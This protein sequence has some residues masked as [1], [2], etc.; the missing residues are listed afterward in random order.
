MRK[1]TSLALALLA[2][3]TISAT[4]P[5]TGWGAVLHAGAALVH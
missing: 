4:M 3:S 5:G 2:A 1:F